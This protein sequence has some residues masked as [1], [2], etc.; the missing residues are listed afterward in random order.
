MPIVEYRV[1]LIAVGRLLDVYVVL[2][3]S[4]AFTTNVVFFVLRG[5]TPKKP[6]PVW[7]KVVQTCEKGRN[8][9]VELPASGTSTHGMAS[10]AALLEVLD[11]Q[12]GTGHSH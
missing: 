2:N 3:T 10:P 4:A 1:Q 7:F 5:T 11:I 12:S 6:G 9:W 8:A